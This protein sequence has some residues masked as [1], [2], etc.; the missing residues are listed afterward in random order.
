VRGLALLALLLVAACAG[1]QASTQA[2]RPSPSALLAAAGDEYVGCLDAR[3]SGPE[4][5]PLAPHLAGDLRTASLAQLSDTSYA[6]PEEAA[7]VMRAHDAVAP[8]RQRYLGRLMHELPAI[9]PIQERELTTNDR[10]NVA[11]VQHR[12][13]WGTYTRT[14]QQVAQETGERIMDTLGRLQSGFPAAAAPEPPVVT[15]CAY[16]ATSMH[17]VS[18]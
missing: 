11:L 12:I 18:Q 7:L 1:N 16:G 3:S 14:R 6:T 15:D 4:F 17:C 5:A 10:L 13:T 9:E 2:A 8:C